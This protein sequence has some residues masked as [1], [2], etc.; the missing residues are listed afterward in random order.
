M[1][2]TIVRVWVTVLLKVIEGKGGE[3]DEVMRN[4]VGDDECSRAAGEVGVPDTFR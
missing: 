2:D 4:S 1:V 3:G